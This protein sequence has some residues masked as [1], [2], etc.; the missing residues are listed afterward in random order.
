MLCQSLDGSEII[1]YAWGGIMTSGRGLNFGAWKGPRWCERPVNALKT[2]IGFLTSMGIH[3]GMTWEM[4]RVALPFSHV[5]GITQA[6]YHAI[7]CLQPHAWGLWPSSGTTE[8]H[9]SAFS[10]LSRRCSNCGVKVLRFRNHYARVPV[11]RFRQ[12]SNE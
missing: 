7:G 3:V 6:S 10:F 5:C 8:L 4:C 12:T 9:M 2:K 1:R 11:S